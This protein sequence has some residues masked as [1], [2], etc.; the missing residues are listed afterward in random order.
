MKYLVQHSFLARLCR[1]HQAITGIAFLTPK[2]GG[3]EV[4]GSYASAVQ[5]PRFQAI[6]LSKEGRTGPL[7]G[8]RVA[9]NMSNSTMLVNMAG[10]LGTTHWGYTSMVMGIYPLMKFPSHAS[11]VL[12]R[13]WLLSKFSSTA[14]GQFTWG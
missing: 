10:F 5:N 11:M 3:D 1:I 7:E 14:S 9:Y 13:G 8:G 4:G 12:L 2:V 6:E